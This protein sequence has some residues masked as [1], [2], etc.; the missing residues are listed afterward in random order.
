MSKRSWLW[1][2]LSPV[3]WGLLLSF[4]LLTLYMLTNFVIVGVQKWLIDDVFMT[5][6]YDKLPFYLFIFAA[7]FMGFLVL[8]PVSA[9]ARDLAFNRFHLSL[10][11]DLMRHVYSIPFGHFQKERTANF[12]YFFTK[13]VRSLAEAITREVPLSIQQVINVIL[14]MVIIGWTSPLILLF[15]VFF[16]GIYFLLGRYFAPRIKEYHRQVQENKSNVVVHIEEGI[17][18]TREVIA[19]HRLKWES[20]IYNRLFSKYFDSVMEE[21]KLE[22]K[23][24]FLSE[25]IK[26]GTN[27]VVLGY[28]GYVVLTGNM[29]LGTFVVMYQF[30]SQ[31]MEALQK[32]FQMF[33]G[34]SG[35][36]AYFERLDE[37]FQQ[38]PMREGELTME[39]KITRL[40]FE[41]V[42]FRYEQGQNDVLKSVDLEI[43]IGKKVAF[44]GTSGGGKTTITQ[45]LLRAIEPTNGEI[46]VNGIPLQQIK[47]TDWTSRVGIVFQDTYLY[48]GSILSNLVLGRG[49]SLAMVK[50]VEACK[51]AQIH[52]FIESLPDGYETVIGERGIT[53]SGG[54][55]QRI[56]LARALLH[57]PEILILDEATSALDMETERQVQHGL[58]RA[59]KGKTMIVIAHRLS[60]V[61]NADVI[62]VLDKGTVV[63]KGTHEELLSVGKVYGSLYVLQK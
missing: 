48:Q 19:F 4:T 37:V 46:A 18:S 54:Q 30:S 51:T 16:G 47:R 34:L 27:I 24:L 57:D 40:Q 13:D 25:P 6:Q 41:G 26:W 53:L 56:S 8:N 10:S 33:M 20:K 62:Y 17:S 50:V 23:H 49:D 2:N 29:T 28:G 45:L 42:T 3:K 12:V 15:V 44:V 55:R 9:Y 38:E 43:P 22:N 1:R 21:G 14:L 39:G 5:G 61:E 59:M 31:L 60:T 36:M 7:G 63:E 35:K 52:E 11:E 32:L 58:D